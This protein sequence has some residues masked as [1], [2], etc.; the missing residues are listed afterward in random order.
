MK[1][2]LLTISFVG[3]V[4]APAM[5]ADLARPVYQRPAV[6]AAPVFSW[7]GV[8]LGINGGGGY[9]TEEYTWNQD[10]TVAPLA[11][12]LAG[13][14]LPP[15]PPLG[16]VQSAHSISGSLFGGQIGADYQIGWVVLGAQADAHWADI[17]GAGSCDVGILKTFAFLSANCSAKVSSFG[18]VTG[19]LGGAVDH[20]LIYAKGG[21]AWGRGSYSESISGS[22]VNLGL[23]L[24]GNLSPSSV[25]VS[26]KG[27]LFGA[28][29][30]YAL[31]ANW[32]AFLEYDHID[33]GTNSITQVHVFTNPSTPP[34]PVLVP[35]DIR[36]QLHIVKVG[37]NY[38]FN[39][40]APVIT[41]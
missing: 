30:E 39:W 24:G 36:E 4:A 5:S 17:E 41:K 28:G 2:L 11:P 13:L 31:A 34:T 14:G 37:V 40:G 27:W 38:R 16:P 8:Y 6:V 23:G 1:K 29:I 9:G 12:I 32:S 7:T 15:V 25:D 19:R 3:L 20:A 33:F 26:R 22:E 18:S 35:Y 10:A 21:W